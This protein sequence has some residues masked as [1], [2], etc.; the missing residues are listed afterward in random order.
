MTIENDDDY[1]DGD[2]YIDS[3]KYRYGDNDDNFDL[4]NRVW[5]AF[6]SSN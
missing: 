2:D 6:R 3:W 1:S 4:N 5:I